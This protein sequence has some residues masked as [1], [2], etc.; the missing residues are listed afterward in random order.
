LWGAGC[1][2]VRCIEIY[3]KEKSDNPA[4]PPLTKNPDACQQD[5]NPLR[6]SQSAAHHRQPTRGPAFAGLNPHNFP[7]ISGYNC[8]FSMIG[9]QSNLR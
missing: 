2:D 1:S 4:H 5:S 7:S 6:T 3:D 8:S 9:F